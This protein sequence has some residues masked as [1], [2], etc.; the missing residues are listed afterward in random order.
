MDEL[1]KK[2]YCEAMIAE[3]PDN[4]EA[5][6]QLAILC[7]RE[8]DYPNALQHYAKAVNLQPDNVTMHYH[9][10]LFFLKNNQWDEALTQFNNVIALGTETLTIA[11]GAYYYSGNLYLA[12]EQLDLAEQHYTHVLTLNSAHSDTLSNMGVICLKRHQP[13]L[14]IDY[15]TKALAVDNDHEDARNNMAATFMQYDRY[16][17]AITHYRELLQ[18]APNNQEYHYNIAVAYMHMG[19]LSE[20]IEHFDWIVQHDAHHAASLNNLAAIYWRLD[21]KDKAQD[22]LSRALAI[23]PNDAASRYM[24][25]AMTHQTDFTAA[26]TEYV[27]NLFDNYA[28]QYDAHLC[29]QLQ[30]QLPEKINTLLSATHYAS[31]LDL[32]CGTGLVGQYLKLHATRLWGVDIS[33]KMLA[34]AKKTGYYDKIIQDDILH[35]FEQTSEHFDCICAAEVFEYFGDLDAVFQSV[36]AHLCPEG[37]FIFSIEVL[38]KALAIK[39]SFFLQETA[40][41]AHYLDYITALAQKYHFNVLHQIPMTARLQNDQPLASCL[42]MLRYHKR[43]TFPVN[44]S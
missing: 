2:A 37:V 30:Y 25:S 1:Q 41:F 35:Y 43:K 28:V 9:L 6:H 19:H 40:R 5:H 23:E 29:Q 22:F 12:K 10:G 42:F 4:A 20:A 33:E 13:Q 16:E 39:Q 27:K 38:D 7:D 32:G 8:Q 31:A 34:N 18:K 11:L 26:P 36:A 14:A 21:Q 24:L 17:N 3:H 15:F 44:A